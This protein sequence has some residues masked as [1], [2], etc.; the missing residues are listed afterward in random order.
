VR[1]ILGPL[2]Q[3]HLLAGEDLR[4]VRAMTVLE[5]IGSADAQQIL[6]GLANG[7]ESAPVTRT[8]R[9]AVERIR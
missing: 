7:V 1:T 3:P 4:S 8:A 9:A 2:E 6:K 5:R